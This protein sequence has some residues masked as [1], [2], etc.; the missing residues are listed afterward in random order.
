MS[1]LLDMLKSDG[2]D[3]GL[4][5][6]GT[7]V[8][9]A[10]KTAILKMLQSKNINNDHINA[11]SKFLDSELGSA[12]LSATVGMAFNYIPPFKN[13]KRAQSLAKEFRVSGI[14]FAGNL[15]ADSALEN[16]MTMANNLFENLPA[17]KEKVRI[18]VPSQNEE[19]NEI[20]KE[21]PKRLQ[22]R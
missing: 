9:K 19:I 5:I 13:D 14:A 10:A 22:N 6:A 8:I 12:A 16:L 15:L 21:Q 20:E 7:Q 18:L 11:V 17:P 1:E 2:K 3:A 4:R